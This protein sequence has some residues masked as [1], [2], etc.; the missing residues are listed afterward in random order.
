MI[1]T[2]ALDVC[3]ILELGLFLPSHR[4]VTASAVTFVWLPS[5]LVGRFHP[6]GQLLGHLAG[7]RKEIPYSILSAK[8]SMGFGC[9]R[10]CAFFFFLNT[11]GSE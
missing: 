5:G 9:Q 7:V 2:R 4:A 8:G 6:H 1:L 11:F 10:G 3:L